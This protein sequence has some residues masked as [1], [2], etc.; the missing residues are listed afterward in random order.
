MSVGKR[1]GPDGTGPDATTNR[2]QPE[3]Y[4]ADRHET[5]MRQ[6]ADRIRWLDTHTDW[7]ARA[8]ADD[9]PCCQ[10][11]RRRKWAEESA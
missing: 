1:K 11:C 6:M 10:R 3:P 9:V 5:V 7:W 2:H 4:N 8:V